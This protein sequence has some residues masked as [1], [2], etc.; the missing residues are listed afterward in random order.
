MG[1]LRNLTRKGDTGCSYKSAGKG[2]YP[3]G[4]I[5]CPCAQNKKGLGEGKPQLLT[6]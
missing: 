6:I 1:E 5:T 4:E 3:T 2:A